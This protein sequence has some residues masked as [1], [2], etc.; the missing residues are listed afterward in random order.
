LE[1][2]T[3]FINMPYP[4][5]IFFI[6]HDKKSSWVGGVD[7]KKKYRYYYP[8]INQ[9]CGTDLFGY[10]MYVP[11]NPLDIIKSEYGKNWKKPILSSQYI[12]NRSPH[13]MKSAGVYSIYEMRSARKDYG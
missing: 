8:L 4:I 5:D 9:V 1:L 13:N 3:K 2:R 10:L 11:C 12:W 7:G 6:Y